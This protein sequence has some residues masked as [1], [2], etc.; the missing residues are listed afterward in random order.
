MERPIQGSHNERRTEEA[1]TRTTHLMDS[2]MGPSAIFRPSV[3]P[4]VRPSHSDGL[5]WERQTGGRR[6]ERAPPAVPLFPALPASLFPPFSGVRQIRIHQSETNISVLT[7]EFVTERRRRRSSWL[8]G[9]SEAK[10]WRMDC[11]KV[12]RGFTGSGSTRNSTTY[13]DS[14]VRTWL[15]QGCSHCS[16]TCPA[17]P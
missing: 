15:S 5:L 4:S 11:R 16:L 6:S 7:S 2:Q 3:R 9:A 1:R 17:Q 12:C 8:V 13:R 14:L 10:K